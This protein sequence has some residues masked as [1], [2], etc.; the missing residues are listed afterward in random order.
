MIFGYASILLTFARNV[1]FVPIYLREIPLAEY[2]AWLATGGALALI[3]I[4]DFGLSGVVTQKLSATYGAKDYKELGSLAGSALMIGC[5]MAAALTAISLVFVGMLPALDP[6]DPTH[7]GTMVRCFLLAIAANALG[8][9]GSTAISLIR[10]LQRPVIAGMIV[11][12]AELVNAAFV[13]IGLFAGKGLYAI[14]GGMLARS[15]IVALG[16]IIGVRLIYSRSLNVRLVVQWRAVQALL[17]DSSRFFISS[18]AMRLQSQGSVLFVGLALGPASAAIYSLTVRAHETVL[19]LIGQINAALVPPATHLLGSGNFARFRVILLRMLLALGAV[20]ALAMSTTVVLNAGFL[21]LWLGNKD[22]AGQG[23]S[24]LMA[25][26]LFVSSLG[27]VGYDALVAQGKFKVISTVFA[28]TSALQI[29]LLSLLLLR[30]DLWIA[31]MAILTTALVWGTVFWRNVSVEIGLTA[32]EAYKLLAELAR[33]VCVSIAAIAGFM[34]FVPAATSWLSLA[35]EGM[36]CVSVLI[37][38]YMLSSSSIR[39]LAREEIGVTL[40]ALRPT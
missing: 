6:V 11:V 21:H 26:A 29:G 31:P 2:G 32:A 12:I 19:M 23:V 16:A 35:A 1:L 33:V 22:F 20:T 37:A 3:L 10:S 14:A 25:A 40:R 17:G 28:L 13:L 5:I 15:V 8:L 18:I 34:L 38:G 39:S 9:I 30:S 24:I 36:A 4:N 27:F 7:G